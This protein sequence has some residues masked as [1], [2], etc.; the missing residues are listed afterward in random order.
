M[1]K[2]SPGRHK[3]SQQQL[4]RLFAC[5]CRASFQ[6]ISLPESRLAARQSFVSYLTTANSDPSLRP[7]RTFGEAA[8]LTR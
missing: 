6:A 7:P 3:T 1:I 4:C 5:K 2:L 8:G